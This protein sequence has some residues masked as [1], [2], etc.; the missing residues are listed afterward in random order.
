[1]RAFD[2]EKWRVALARV[3]E[4]NARNR[5]LNLTAFKKDKGVLRAYN[6]T[7]LVTEWMSLQP[8]I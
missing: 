1:M 4:Q 7:D 8:M 3:R 5:L 6:I 2:E